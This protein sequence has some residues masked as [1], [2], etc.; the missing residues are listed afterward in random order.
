MNFLKKQASNLKR[1]LSLRKWKKIIARLDKWSN[2]SGQQWIGAVVMT[3]QLFAGVIEHLTIEIIHFLKTE[4]QKAVYNTHCGHFGRRYC[5]NCVPHPSFWKIVCK[6]EKFRASRCISS[7]AWYKLSFQPSTTSVRFVRS[8][9]SKAKKL[10]IYQKLDFK[11][12][13][14]RF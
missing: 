7:S 14:T 11:S 5:Y 2:C 13:K 10:D 1:K 6:G 8:I 4:H 12:Q 3:T 9:F